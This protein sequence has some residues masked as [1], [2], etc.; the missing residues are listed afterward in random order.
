MYK[1]HINRRYK[2]FIDFIKDRI[3]KLSDEKNIHEAACG[4]AN[5]SYALKNLGASVSISDICPD[6]LNLAKQ[7]MDCESYL[8]NAKADK[9]PSGALMYSHGLLE[10][11][12]D[13]DIKDIIKNQLRYC[14]ELVHYVPGEKYKK[15]SFGDERLLSKNYWG[16]LCRP[17]KIIGFNNGY[18]LI[19]YWDNSKAF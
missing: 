5:I 18:D 4:C 14:K 13:E 19:L 9:F 8:L 2:V 12:N 7:N 16:R 17:H 3:N 11:F 1:N 15:P 6:M 10:H